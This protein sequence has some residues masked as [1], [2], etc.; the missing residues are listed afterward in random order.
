[1]T[2]T[3]HGSAA[4]DGAAPRKLLRL[5]EA[6]GSSEGRTQLASL[7]REAGMAKS[8]AHRLLGV[9]VSEGWAA[10]HDGGSYELGPRARALAAAAMRDPVNASVDGVLQDLSR[11]VSQTVHLGLAAGDHFIYTH[12]VE[13]PQGFG[14]A[15]HVGMRQLLH[16]TAI[17]KCILAGMQ[18]TEVAELVGRTGLAARTPRT[19]QTL[20]ALLDDLSRV[21]AQGFA[22]DEEENEANIRC[23]AVPVQTGGRTV[24]AVSISTVTLL[25]DP[26]SVR[27]FVPAARTAA[28][29]VQELL[30]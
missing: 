21:R 5:L 10:V 14:I 8:T 4:G 23:L 29:R 20:E 24:G 22:L 12:K 19:H 11:T 17:G 27:G 13:G 6:L 26:D 7:A 2:T 25:T 30:A 9:L 15:S 28:F 16:S 18:D 3:T 1:M